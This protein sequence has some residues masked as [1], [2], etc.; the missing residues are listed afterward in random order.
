MRKLRQVP[1]VEELEGNKCVQLIR[2]VMERTVMHSIGVLAW[3]QGIKHLHPSAPDSPA[4]RDNQSSFL[5][6]NSNPL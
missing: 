1:L 3:H 6:K 4:R 5:G 2:V